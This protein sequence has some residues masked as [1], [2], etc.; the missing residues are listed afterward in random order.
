MPRLPVLLVSL[1]ACAT[2]RG[3][4]DWRDWY[5]DAA[6][7][8]VEEAVA[9]TDVNYDFTG[10]TTI[11]DLPI[12]PDFQTWFGRESTLPDASC[13]GWSLHTALPAV[14]E[15]IVTLHPRFYIKVNGCVPDDFTIDSDEKYYGSFFVQD[16]TGGFFVLGDSK[17]AHFEMG[18]R[19]RIE[20]NAVKDYFSNVMIAA[21]E[22]T[23]VTRGPEP[24]YYQPV[25]RLLGP[26]DVGEVFRVTGTVANPIGTF[27]E[28]YLC[29]GPDPDTTLMPDLDRDEDGGEIVPACAH[30]SQTGWYK[31]SIDIELARR[32]V[33][34]PVGT[35]L[36]VTGPVLESFG[37]YPVIVMRLGQITER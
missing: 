13:E 37:D 4:V 6:P 22:V 14:I 7:L 28:V 32:G 36:E 29:A 1:S 8:D 5:D 20:V 24:I 27:G 35:P 23:V 34:W 3:A 33:A 17:V 18:D 10:P 15:G 9:F 21:H 12:P 30:R 2:P 26:S 16:A 19:V 31:L 25:D 11:A